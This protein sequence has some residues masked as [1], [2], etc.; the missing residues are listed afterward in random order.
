MLLSPTLLR[1]ARDW[2]A[3]ETARKSLAMTP[4]Q[5]KVFYVDPTISTKNLE[6]SLEPKPNG[7]RKFTVSIHGDHYVKVH[8][9]K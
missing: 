1:L 4:G 3:A 8:C 2:H 9:I 5:T 6:K 7:S